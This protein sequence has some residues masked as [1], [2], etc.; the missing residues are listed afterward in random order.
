M[1]RHRRWCESLR[2]IDR[3]FYDISARPAEVHPLPEPGRGPR[4]E[5]V[6]WYRISRPSSLRSSDGAVRRLRTRQKCAGLAERQSRKFRALRSLRHNVGGYAK[7][8]G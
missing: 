8:A 2:L 5:D 6:D 7:W 1:G 4:R 3:T